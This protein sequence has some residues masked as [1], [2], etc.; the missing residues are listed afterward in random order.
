MLPAGP[1][2]L[3]VP[4]P[5]L[6]AAAIIAGIVAGAA[7]P[8]GSGAPDARGGTQDPPVPPAP[9]HGPTHST[10]MLD[11]DVAAALAPGGPG[12]A[13]IE[14]SARWRGDLREL[15]AAAIDTPPG[16]LL[17]G[18]LPITPA[19]RVDLTGLVTSPL[20]HVESSG[21][22]WRDDPFQRFRKFH[23]GTDFKAERGTPVLAA[24]GGTVRIAGVQNGYGNV[25]YIDHGDGLITRYGHLAK[26]LVK[27]GATI[28]AGDKL[29][30]VGATGRATGPHLHFEVRIAGRAVDPV[31]AMRIAELQRTDPDAAAELE[32][33]LAPEAQATA[34]DAQDPTNRK[35]A[36]QAKG[37]RPERRGRAARDRNLW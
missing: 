11:V 28:T 6:G 22:G 36:R 30:L 18:G 23:K 24:G 21:Y 1:A 8:L 20:P 29:G 9:A 19:P 4:R 15:V 31:L 5:R 27:A 32:P 25:V 3:R 10:R 17:L 37:P 34:L 14:L 16:W 26:I 33:G 35:A 12:E 13:L 7:L 2:P